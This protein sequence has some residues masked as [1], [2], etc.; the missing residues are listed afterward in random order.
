MIDFNYWSP[1]YF[2]FGKGNEAQT[3]ELVH[4][5]GILLTWPGARRGH[6]C[7]GE[8]EESAP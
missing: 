4:R 5:F 7:N 6:A 2:A 3:G 1:T 8:Q